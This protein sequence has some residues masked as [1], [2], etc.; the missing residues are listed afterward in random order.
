MRVFLKPS[1]RRPLRS[2]NIGNHRPN[3]IHKPRYFP[4]HDEQALSC[5]CLALPTG[6]ECLRERVLRGLAVNQPD[7]NPRQHQRHFTRG[8]VTSAAFLFGNRPTPYQHTTSTSGST[9][10]RTSRQISAHLSQLHPT[11]HR[12][13]RDPDLT[14]NSRPTHTKSETHV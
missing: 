7:N 2:L 11:G 5:H 6:G 4:L 9:P 1:S 13:I 14:R 8:R 10:H 3:H 12:K